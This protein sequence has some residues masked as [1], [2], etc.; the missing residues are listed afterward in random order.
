MSKP[1]GSNSQEWLSSG[2]ASTE[3]S[4]HDQDAVSR[5]QEFV[6]R[7]LS[8]TITDLAKDP[9]AAV[10]VPFWGESALEGGILDFKETKENGKNYLES[11]FGVKVDESPSE[12]IDGV[13]VRRIA[14]NDK[15]KR[16]DIVGGILAGVR[17]PIDE[18]H[19]RELAEEIPVPEVE[20]WGDG[21]A[22][23]LVFDLDDEETRDDTTKVLKGYLG[24]EVGSEDS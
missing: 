11:S 3:Y 14:E 4:S 1:E 18:T 9:G 15:E 24:I 8:E 10:E 13:K 5:L 6:S 7:R 20:V 16:R 23:A 19:G 12:I 21:S 17:S 22:V 2:E